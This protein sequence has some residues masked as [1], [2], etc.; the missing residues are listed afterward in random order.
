[1]GL[2]AFFVIYSVLL[3]FSPQL[4]TD[5]NIS[6]ADTISGD[7]TGNYMLVHK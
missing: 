6:N 4:V 3:I 7:P 1:M 5:G 2:G